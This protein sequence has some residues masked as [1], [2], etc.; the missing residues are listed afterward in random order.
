MRQIYA[1]TWT[2]TLSASSSKYVYSDRLKAGF[3]LTVLSCVAYS[4]EAE[5]ADAILIGIENGGENTLC[6]A[7][8]ITAAKD[9]LA[10]TAPLMVGEHDRVFCSFP[11]ADTGDKI[12]LHI[13]G[14][15]TRREA[16]QTGK[17]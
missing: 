15:L 1:R 7:K 2:K 8:A 17:E 3:V 12:E 9:S 11:D 10:T 5:A 13:T 6:E 4:A 14:I 16:W